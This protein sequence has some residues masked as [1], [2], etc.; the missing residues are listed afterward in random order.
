MEIQWQRG[1]PESEFS[2]QFAQGMADR[3]AVSFCKYG[4]IAEAYPSRVDAIASLKK[5]L[6]RY[7][8]DGNTEWLMD[9]ANFAMIEFMHP[10]HPLAHF[11]A[12][13]SDR[14]PGRV[15]NNGAVTD[16]ANTVGRENV[17]RGGSNLVTAG[18]FYQHEGD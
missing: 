7:E 11:V 1:I 8:Q 15:W 13:D 3:V 17:R 16:A 5:R 9:V 4:A 10:R 2:Q 12:T 18:G 14:S 6:E